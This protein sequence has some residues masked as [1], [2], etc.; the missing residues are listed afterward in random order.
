[1]TT[2]S[3]IYY[4]VEALFVL[5][6]SVPVWSV[7][8]SISGDITGDGVVDGRDALKIMRAVQGLETVSEAEVALG[9]VWPVPGLDGRRIG[10]GKLTREDAELILKQS[11]GLLPGG[12]ISGD[13]SRSAPVIDNFYPRSGPIGTAVTLEGQ[14]FLGGLPNENLV[15]FGGIPAPI[16]AI[17]GTRITTEVPSGAETGL[18]EV[19]TPGGKA[20]GDNDFYVTKPSFGKLILGKGLNP[21]D[22]TIVSAHGESPVNPD[23]SF[24]TPAV[25]DELTLLGAASSSEANNTYLSLLFSGT[26][27]NAAGIVIDSLSTA[28]TLVFMHPFFITRD[29]ANAK[30]LFD[31]MDTLPEIKQLADVIDRRYPAG[32]NG[33]ADEEVK[34]AWKLAVAALIDALPDLFTVSFD[35]SPNAAIFSF[36]DAKSRR[37]SSSVSAGSSLP[38]VFLLD[39]NGVQKTVKVYGVDRDYL[40][41]AYIPDD[42]TLKMKLDNGYSPVDWLV[43]FFQVDPESMPLGLNTPFTE[44]RARGLKHTGYQ[45]TNFVAASQWTTNLNLV[46]K[47]MDFAMDWMK[48]K[49][50]FQLL[51]E[52]GV[53]VLRMFSGGMNDYQGW[54]KD[55]IRT[56]DGGEELYFNAIALNAALVFVDVWKL[57]KNNADTLSGRALQNAVKFGAAAIG[58]EEAGVLL[59]TSFDGKRAM[60]ILLDILVEIVKGAAITGINEGISAAGKKLEGTLQ[61]VFTSASGILKGLS[62]L[63]F[64]GKIAERIA[65]MAGYLLNPLDMELSPGPTPLETILVVVGDPFGPVLTQVSPLRGG[66]GSLVAITGQRFA[67]KIKE[68]RVYFGAYEAEVVSGSLTELVV[69]VPTVTQSFWSDIKVN[70]AVETPASSQP[71]SFT[72]QFTIVR[73]PNVTRMNPT[74]G[75]APNPNSPSQ[76]PN[77]TGTAVTLFGSRLTPQAGEY[78]DL[79]FGDLAA[80]IDQSTDNSLAFTVPSA[81]KPGEYGVSIYDPVSRIYTASQTFRVVGAPII[82][83]VTPKSAQAGQLVELNGKELTGSMILVNDKTVD[84]LV[85]SD[86]RAQF[87]LPTVGMEGDKIT[88]YAVNPAGKSEEKNITRLPGVQVPKLPT[89]AQGYALVVT[90][91]AMGTVKDGKLSLDEIAQFLNKQLDLTQWDDRNEKIIQIWREVKDENGVVSMEKRDEYEETPAKPNNGAAGHETREIWRRDRLLNGSTNEYLIQTIDLDATADQMEEADYL[92]FYGGDPSAY[93]GKS[94]KNTITSQVQGQ[95]DANSFT[96]TPQAELTLPNNTLG[97]EGSITVSDGCRLIMGRTAM[98]KTLEIKANSVVIQSGTFSSAEAE[99]IRIVNGFGN[100]IGVPDY[101]SRVSVWTLYSGGDGV[102]IEGGGKNTVMAD[103]RDCPGVGLRTLNTEQNTYKIINAQNCSTGGLSAQA[104][105][106]STWETV[107]IQGGGFGALFDRCIG[108]AI[109]TGF[110]AQNCQGTGLTVQGGMFN[111][112]GSIYAYGPSQVYISKCGQMGVQI[113]QSESNYLSNALIEDCQDNGFQLGPDAYATTAKEI[114]ILNCKNGLVLTGRGTLLNTFKN[115]Y[116]GALFTLTGGRSWT[117]KGNRESGVVIQD[118]A[119]NNEFAAIISMDNRGCGVLIEGAETHTNKFNQGGIGCLLKAVGYTASALN[120]GNGGEGILIQK[121]AHHNTVTDFDILGSGQAIEIPGVGGNGVA[122]QDEGTD[123]NCIEQS[124]IGS[125]TLQYN[126]TPILKPNRGYGIVVQNKANGTVLTSNTFGVNLLGSVWIDYSRPLS[127]DQ[128]YSAT[129]SGN[130]SFIE[131]KAAEALRSVTEYTSRERTSI[132]IS[133]SS[134]VLVANN[135]FSGTTRGLLIEGENSSQHFVSE[136]SI[137]GVSECVRVE[138][139]VDD[140]FF[141]LYASGGKGDGLVL[142]QTQKTKLLQVDINNCAN[143]PLIVD[144]CKN[145]SI[146]DSQF[147]FPKNADTGIVVADSENITMES[148]KISTMQGTSLSLLRSHNIELDRVTIWDGLAGVFVHQ[149]DGFTLLGYPYIANDPDQFNKTIGSAGGPGV[150]ILDSQ[151]VRIGSPN[152]V[153]R[154]YMNDAQGILVQ[155]DS[156]QNVQIGGCL[157]YQNKQ[158]GIRVEGGKNIKIGGFQGQDA[159]YIYGNQ[160]DGILIQGANTGAVIYHNLI[161]YTETGGMYYNKQN[162]VALQGG[163]HHTLIWGNTIGYN[164]QNGIWI[165]DGAHHNQI[166]FNAIMSNSKNGVLVEGAGSV[167]NQITRNSI[168]RNSQLGIKLQGGNNSVAAPTV[169]VME[170]QVNNLIGHIDAPDGSLVEIFADSYYDEGE[171]LIATARILYKNFATA[172]KLP[173][174]QYI[175]ATITHPDGDTSE[176]GPA[177]T[178]AK[179]LT[180]SQTYVFASDAFGQ[181]DIFIK[182]PSQEIPVRLTDDPS[183]DEEPQLSSQGRYIAFTSN[184]SGNQDIWVMSSSGQQL[185]QVTSDSAPDYHPAWQPGG[186]QVLFVSERDGNPEIYQVRVNPE[187]IQ[188][189]IGPGEKTLNA[190]DPGYTGKAAGDAAAVRFN[191]MAGLLTHFLI[192]LAADPA[193]FAWKIIPYENNQPGNTVIAEGTANPTQIGWNIVET[194]KIAIPENYLIAVYF[195]EAGKPKIGLSYGGRTYFWWTYSAQNNKWTSESYIPFMIRAFVTPLDPIRLTNNAAADTEPAWSPDRTQITF[196]STRGGNTDLWIANADGSSP[197]QLTDGKGKNSKATW[198]PGGKTIAFVSDRDGNV[199]LYS[200]QTDGTGLRRLTNHSGVDSDP[201][202]NR[203]GAR[204]FFC[205]DRDA[206][207]EIYSLSASSLQANRLTVTV[208]NS[209]EPHGSPAFQG[210]SVAYLSLDEENPI[211]NQPSPSRLRPFAAPVR[212]AITSGQAKTG[213]Q[214]VIDVT[215]EGAENLGNLAFDLQYDASC[216]TLVDIPSDSLSIHPLFALNPE[217]FPS[218]SGVIRFNSVYATGL[219]GTLPIMRLLF[220]VDRGVLSEQAAIAAQNLQGCNVQCVDIPIDAQDGVVTIIQDAT[221]VQSW[222]LYE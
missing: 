205:S 115:L 77:F 179:R 66:E 92:V 154:F 163:V 140:T 151:N 173:L 12:T 45:D 201:A 82:S 157:I 133:N 176:F 7:D 111:V 47:G 41:A 169:E 3:R 174:G 187:A 100:T 5:A 11:V 189:E 36:L 40:T 23:G 2:R 130:S 13:Y 21:S 136:N 44:I 161:G 34:E 209:M 183:T 156:T 195:L 37:Q 204:L 117:A 71:S 128:T 132:R 33:L 186:D 158:E 73:A 99:A 147:A 106:Y 191:S 159:N 142:V 8:H 70:V 104:E 49:D 59:A 101:S 206:G 22:F 55:A 123:E 79:Y 135:S 96:L 76:I 114:A 87:V 211:E 190:A 62:K 89:L 24:T 105:N 110:Y 94:F 109:S 86:T 197:K 200:I 88:I 107:S 4:L 98:R 113:A 102:V 165:T 31:L 10:D 168:T 127:N 46:K 84:L 43:G 17:S 131:S 213:E 125:D 124:R 216:L 52:D 16:R 137:T 129:V 68:N 141:D 29:F 1:M 180:E 30:T 121:G 145:I 178:N 152:R 149:C 112:I 69:K 122:I 164:Q 48:T 97:V 58:Q 61:E 38:P 221:S 26:T 134:R 203:S 74:W 32:V 25:I 108:N 182:R 28:K 218:T 199:E 166:G 67:P 220:T 50:T 138:K 160:L 184:R 208:G 57:F 155:G 27:P 148:V 39:D 6:C 19:W 90:T 196:T 103:I 83:D 53:Y 207:M 56:I 93:D 194:G 210:T 171:T 85:A 75:F 120:P 65:G 181:K 222:M 172:A 14:N 54:D 81:A 150:H 91:T 198:S 177:N 118:G 119:N 42:H 185:T 167:S 9:D 95:I 192:Y 116:V 202:W 60:Q 143:N 219:S 146:H 139:S 15:F 126:P 153:V 144:R 63:S 212:L 170:D 20:I 215:L 175:H 18:I 188:G 78:Y 80:K 72:E 64:M 193:P 217:D 162:G 51:P 214:I 35:N